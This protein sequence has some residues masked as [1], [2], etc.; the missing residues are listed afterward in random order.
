MKKLTILASL[1]VLSMSGSAMAIAPTA[2][3]Q[4]LIEGVPSGTGQFLFSGIDGSDP[5]LAPNGT[6]VYNLIWTAP[7]PSTATRVCVVLEAV[8]MTFPNCMVNMTTDITSVMYA[9]D[10]F[11]PICSGF[12]GPFPP[13]PAT[14]FSNAIMVLGESQGT[15]SVNGI[16]QIPVFPFFGAQSITFA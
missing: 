15:P 16:I 3:R 6:C 14:A 4:I 11:T 8:T 1:A 7:P 2:G 12:R 10:G 13:F 9:G 5:V